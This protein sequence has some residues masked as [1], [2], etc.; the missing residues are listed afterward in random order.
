MLLNRWLY[1]F[2]PTVSGPQFT[3]FTSTKVQLLTP[4]ARLN[5]C[6][7]VR[8]RLWQR[9]PS[10]SL[11]SYTYLSPVF[12]I[13]ISLRARMLCVYIYARMYRDRESDW[14]MQRESGGGIR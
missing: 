2:N 3:C 10:G 8:A 4:R 1:V 12:S 7:C 13:L 11:H 14:C 5:V 9:L 6:V